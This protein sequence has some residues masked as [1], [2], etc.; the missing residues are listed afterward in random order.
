MFDYYTFST[1]KKILLSILFLIGGVVIVYVISC[2]FNGVS[3]LHGNRDTYADGLIFG[4]IGATTE[5]IKIWFS[6]ESE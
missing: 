6:K 5:V 3:I 1:K 2:L 4:L